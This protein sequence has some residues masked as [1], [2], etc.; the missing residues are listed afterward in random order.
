[1]VSVVARGDDIGFTIIPFFLE[2]S[3]QTALKD[4]Q[5][6]NFLGYVDTNK[7]T[8][9]RRFTYLE[10]GSPVVTYDHWSLKVLEEF[11][12]IEQ[13]GP[14]VIYTTGPEDA[15]TAFDKFVSKYYKNL[16]IYNWDI[17]RV[18]NKQGLIAVVTDYECY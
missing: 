3:L 1:M 18:E 11:P 8:G 14:W 2:E 12:F 4:Y 9:K 17:L 10:S 13:E 5:D 6:D 15:S 16:H 7:N